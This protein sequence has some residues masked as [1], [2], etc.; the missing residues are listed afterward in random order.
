M[1]AVDIVN[2]DDIQ[3]VLAIVQFEIDCHT[4]V[5]EHE[6]GTF[7]PVPPLPRENWDQLT[8]NWSPANI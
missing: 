7:T 5:L 4:A 8:P 1:D 2:E 6:R 3:M